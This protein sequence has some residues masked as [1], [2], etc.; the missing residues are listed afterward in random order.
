MRPAL[1]SALLLA[2]AACDAAGPVVTAGLPALP[3]DEAAAYREDAAQLALRYQLDVARDS[4][5]VEL[6][7]DLVESLYA[8]LVRARASAAGDSVAGIHTFPF[9]S[10]HEVIVGAVPGA[11]WTAGWREGRALTGYE[12]VDA[13]VRRYELSLDAFHDFPWGDTAVLRSETPLNTVA[14]GRRFGAAPE[15]RYGEPN[16]YL[17]DGNDIRAERL[18]GAWRL[19]FSVGWGDCPAGCIYRRTWTFVVGDG[20]EVEY[21]GV[22]ENR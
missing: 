13:L 19:A 8:A 20:G 18:D 21:L 1:L 12:P 2:L 7:E 6:P 16:G 15:V 17:G 14:L 3:P 22:R 11:G 10:T 4:S 5:T 9:R